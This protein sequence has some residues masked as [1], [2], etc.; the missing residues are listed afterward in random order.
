MLPEITISTVDLNRLDLL[1][2]TIP[3]GHTFDADALL[4]ELG[5]ANIVHP[6]DVPPRVVTMNS[7]VRFVVAGID[8]EL[9]RTLVYP[10]DAVPS[11]AHL[12]VLTPVG[13][14]ML[15]LSEG[16]SMGW[17]QHDGRHIQVT[18]L[19]VLYQPERQGDFHL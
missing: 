17:A 10:K 14:A 2:D 19:K 11:E 16:D 8:G 13:C 1:L 7:T 18:V 9:C 15:G 12:S 3:S 5:R 4:S 6:W